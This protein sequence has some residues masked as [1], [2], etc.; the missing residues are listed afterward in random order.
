MTLEVKHKQ[1]IHCFP[2]KFHWKLPSFIA[3]LRIVNYFPP[4][5]FFLCLNIDFRESTPCNTK[6]DV[7]YH[8]RKLEII[9]YYYLFVSHVMRKKILNIFSLGFLA[10]KIITSNNHSCWDCICFIQIPISSF[11]QNLIQKCYDLKKI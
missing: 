2:W 9:L 3:K 1:C 10:T 5:L 11:Q 8:E 6:S 7:I 4:K